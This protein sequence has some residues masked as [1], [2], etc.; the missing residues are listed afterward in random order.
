MSVRQGY[1]MVGL[2]STPAYWKFPRSRYGHLVFGGSS[3][4][5]VGPTITLVSPAAAVAKTTPVVVTVTSVNPMRM[6]YATFTFAGDDYD[7]CGFFQRFGLSFSGP[8]NQRATIAN[9]YQFTWLRD[10]GWPSSFILTVQALD[11][12]GN[13]SVGGGPVV[14]V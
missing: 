3:S 8:T 11:A 9:G 10:G 5:S 4:S 2:V 13:L 6:V 12:A 14:L 7:E 1:S